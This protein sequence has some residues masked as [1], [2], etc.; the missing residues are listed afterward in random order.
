MAV[1]TREESKNHVNEKDPALIRFAV[2]KEM[3]IWIQP[4]EILFIQS[5]DHYVKTLVRHENRKKW[6]IRHSTL[7]EI[8]PLLGNHNFIR[9]NK[10]YVIN[11]NWVSHFDEELKTIYLEDGFPIPLIHRISPFILSMF[12]RSNE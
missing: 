2:N 11:K 6:T 10:F 12:R 7:K 8:L 1:Y 5:A 3:F 9:L 4:E